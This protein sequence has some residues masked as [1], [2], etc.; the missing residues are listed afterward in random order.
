MNPIKMCQGK[1]TIYKTSVGTFQK[2]CIILKE[3]PGKKTCRVTSIN[4]KII[5]SP[6]YQLL[7]KQEDGMV[8]LSRK[9]NKSQS[10][11]L[12]LL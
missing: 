2:K 5:S 10:T 1:S 6:M 12:S 3:L 11:F 8:F 9:G 7:L 4:L